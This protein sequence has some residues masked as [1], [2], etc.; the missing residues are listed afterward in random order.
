ML[1][2]IQSLYPFIHPF[3]MVDN[4]AGKGEATLETAKTQF[5]SVDN[6]DYSY[7]EIGSGNGIPLVMLVHFTATMDYWDPAIV[8]GLAKHRKVIVFNN[9]GIGSTN[10]VPADNVSQMS[11]DAV[12]FIKALGLTKVDL[13][14]F[15]LG[16]FVAQEIAANH[17]SLVNKVILV[18][19]S[20]KGDGENLLNIV[21][22]AYAK[23]DIADVRE[24][25]FFSPSEQGQVAAKAFIQRV[26][27]RTVERDPESGKEVIDAQV[28]AIV[29]WGAT[30]DQDALLKRIQQPVLI[31]QGN[32]DTM[33]P[34]ESS[35]HMFKTLSNA[36]LILY[37]DA[38]HGSIFHYHASFLN[39]A[40]HFLSQ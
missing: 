29:T 36:Q 38:G 21:G 13:L 27:S 3:Y 22:E 25:L 33:L 7:R 14:G 19:T 12:S 26:S 10:G 17:A 34:S 32:H 4:G 24:F 9:R 6:I 30:K 11:E 20:A 15:S 8:N 31:V 18:G 2:M 39:A 28:N 16:G 23:K 5:I 40:N 1:Q 37:P 35:I